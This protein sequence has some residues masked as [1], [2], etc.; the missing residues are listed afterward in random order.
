MRSNILKTGTG[1]DAQKQ[2]LSVFKV[3][4]AS[5]VH[6]PSGLVRHQKMVQYAPT[7]LDY[8]CIIEFYLV[9]SD[10][11]FH[12]GNIQGNNNEI[13]TAR[14]DMAIGHNPGINEAEQINP[15]SEVN[16]AFQAKTASPAETVHKNPQA[17]EP[18]P[19]TNGDGTSAAPAA[20]LQSDGQ[21]TA[22][23]E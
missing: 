14:S 21:A 23:G 3:A 7:L 19:K 8:S 10:M 5:P 6:I 16:K 1:S 9:T 11:A 4:I 18:S 12:P 13:Q 2:F 20:G 15:V 17:A 22:H